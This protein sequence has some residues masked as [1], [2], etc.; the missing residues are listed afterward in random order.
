MPI[1]AMARVQ[2]GDKR[3]DSPDCENMTPDISQG[4]IGGASIWVEVGVSN[5]AREVL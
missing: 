4:I 5:P 3:L 2:M 1:V